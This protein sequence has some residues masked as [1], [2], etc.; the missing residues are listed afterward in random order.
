M[1]VSPF[2]GEMSAERTIVN[3]T[4]TMF[5]W[6]AQNPFTATAVFFGGAIVAVM[7][8]TYVF[9]YRMLNHQE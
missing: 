8:Y 4:E 2:F 3:Y 9:D 6:F 5:H 7:L 1:P